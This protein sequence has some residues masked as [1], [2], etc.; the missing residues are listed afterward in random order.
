MGSRAIDAYV[1]GSGGDGRAGTF[2]ELLNVR[3]LPAATAAFSL[4]RHPDTPHH[5]LDARSG[6]GTVGRFA[7]GNAA[8]VVA[9][10]HEATD[11]AR[12]QPA[13]LQEHV[14]A[15][16]LVSESQ[17]AAFGDRFP[18]ERT[19]VVPYGVDTERFVPATLPPSGRLRRGPARRV[20]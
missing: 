4:S 10:F 8:P 12:R 19:F 14:T 17:R 5:V 16:I 11:A 15:A 9:T 18:A 3:P 13:W 1:V 20:R 6:L 2:R 7:C